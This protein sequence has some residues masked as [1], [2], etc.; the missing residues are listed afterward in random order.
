MNGIVPPS[1][2]ARAGAPNAACDACSN[3]A[4]SQ[5]ANVGAF[6]P[7]PASRP[8]KVTRAP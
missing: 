8:A 7:G 5:G 6:Q 3:E 2:K 1:P 4:S